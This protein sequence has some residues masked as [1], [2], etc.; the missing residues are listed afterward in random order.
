MRFDLDCLPTDPVL[1]QKMLR[2]MVEAVEVERDELK[3]AKQTVKAQGLT[4]EKLEHRL[5]RL[6]RVQ[7]GRSSEKMDNAQLR[8]M[9]EDVDGIC[10]PANDD[11]PASNPKPERKAGTRAPIPAHIPRLTAEHRPEPCRCGGVETVICE[12]VTEVLDYV[13]ARFRVLRHVRPR[14]ACR[15]CEAI[16]QVPAID[17][18]LPKVMASSAL[19]AHL[20]VSRFADHQPWHVNRSCGGWA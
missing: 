1:L 12:D 5:A 14:I 6:L 9:F 10:E 2:E 7:F 16:R 15:S 17:L 8:M 3:V 11:V 19:L 4:I 18:P 20:V 13:P